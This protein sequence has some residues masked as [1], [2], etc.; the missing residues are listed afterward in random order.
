MKPVFGI[1]REKENKLQIIEYENGNG[2]FHFH[3]QIELCFVEEGRIDAI[4]NNKAKSLK[5]GDI[6]IALSFN[7]HVYIPAD[8]A[9]FTVIII[10]LHM[11][12]KFLSSINNKKI[13]NPFITDSALTCRIKEYISKLKKESTNEI[14][15]I[16][17]I[18]LILGVV[19]DNLSFDES[20]EYIAES[21]LLSKLLLH[22]HDNYNKNIT[23][24]SI[25][26]KFGYNASYIS[27]YFKSIIDIGIAQ[28][29]NIVRLKNAIELMN[30][31][32]HSITYCAL[33]SG[34]TSLR[35]FYRVFQ[36][37]FNCSPKE[38]L[39]LL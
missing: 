35:T 11:C 18:Y 21:Q 19:I 31:K 26:A 3:S 1:E 34:F 29:I 16:G 8:Y 15:K 12:E 23:L 20:D 5:E 38:Y 14:E 10:P 7:T 13:S 6:S 37:E 28:Y 9:K 33:E 30:T 25:A 24:S 2:D 32:K 27:R 22:I 39:E 4:V 17:Y 36:N